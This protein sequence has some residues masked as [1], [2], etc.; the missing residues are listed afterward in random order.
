MGLL[1]ALIV[2]PAMGAMY[3]YNHAGSRFDVEYLFLLTEMDLAIHDAVLFGQPVDTSQFFP[4]YFFI[5][6]RNAPDT[7]WDDGVPWLPTQPYGC[8]PMMH[9]GQRLLCRFIGAGRASHPFHTHGNH[10]LVIA[11]DGRLLESVPGAG[12]DLAENAFS[13][14]VAPGQTYDAIFEWTGE[15]LG[16]DVFGHEQDI[17]VPPLNDF[18]NLEAG[19]VD[20]NGNGVFDSVPMAMHEY[21][22]DHGKPFPVALPHNQDLTFGQMYSG[23]PFLGANGALPPGEG[24]FN[25]MGAFVYMWHSHTEKELT[26]NDIFPGGMMTHLMVMPHIMN[27]Q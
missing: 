6:G 19:D 4:V 1:G 21:A 11:R 14:P 3:A 18:P 26:N 23:S 9:L 5:N 10:F 7:M 25:P 24:G 8:M 2:R 17:N 22:P 27:E 12:P 16:W 13:A 15:K 20:H